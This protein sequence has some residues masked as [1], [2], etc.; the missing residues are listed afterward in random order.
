MVLSCFSHAAFLFF[1]T[2][3]GLPFPMYSRGTP[4][5]VERRYFSGGLQYQ[6][7]TQLAN[8]GPK[9]E[10]NKLSQRSL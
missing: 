2:S 7:L 8:A 4:S 1:R 9:S 10:L 3:G 6:F 5:Y